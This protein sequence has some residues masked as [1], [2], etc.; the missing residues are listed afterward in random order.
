MFELDS[1]NFK[2][3]ALF[4]EENIW[5]LAK[6]LTHKGAREEDLTILF[7][8]NSTQSVAIFNQKSG[9]KNEPVVWDYHV[10]L[11]NK[12]DD[13]YIIYDFDS[14]LKFGINANQYLNF[15]F[16]ASANTPT[17]Y[18]AQFRLVK[19]HDYL[20]RFSSDRSH[21]L[22]VIPHEQFP[23]YPPINVTNPD[24]AMYLKDLYDFNKPITP[25]EHLFSLNELQKIID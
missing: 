20:T 17:Q 16:P 14:K 21:M 25:N 10:V 9:L 22:G 3:T 13:H 4:C 18:N 1:N 5:H 12:A 7:I 15:S 6:S 24:H 8:S 11:L 23:D 19:A 2:Y